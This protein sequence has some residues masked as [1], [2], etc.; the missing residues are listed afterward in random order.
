MDKTINELERYA[1]VSVITETNGPKYPIIGQYR[2][3]IEDAE[4][5]WFNREGKAIWITSD[6]G[7][8]AMITIADIIDLKIVN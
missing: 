6:S 1:H 8:E 4:H 5:Y 7:F 3:R 2:G